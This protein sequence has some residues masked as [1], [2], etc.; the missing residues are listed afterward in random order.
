MP[1]KE[2]WIS[3]QK[4]GKTWTIFSHLGATLQ[5]GLYINGFF[6]AEEYVRAYASSFHG[7]SIK[8]LKEDGT[9]WNS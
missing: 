1:Y 7:Y 9:E 4:V 3:I 8:V 6:E 5:S 2:K